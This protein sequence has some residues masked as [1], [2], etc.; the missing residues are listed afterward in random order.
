MVEHAAVNRVVVGS[1]PTSGANYREL[2]CFGFIFF[3]TRQA[4][5]TSAKVGI[6][7][8]GSAR[9]IER[10][11]LMGSSLAKMVHG[12]WCGPKCTPPELLLCAGNERLKG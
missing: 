7:K 12:Y 3:K 10:T 1:S 5:S 4:N 8:P 11:K 9:T 6:W 2:G